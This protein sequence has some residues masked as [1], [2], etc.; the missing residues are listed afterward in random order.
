MELKQ[1]LEIVIKYLDEQMVN[2]PSK[3]IADVSNY[4]EDLKGEL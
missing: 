1:A 3:E 2:A 4:L